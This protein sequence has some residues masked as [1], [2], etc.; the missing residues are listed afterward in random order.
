MSATTRTGRRRGAWVLLVAFGLLALAAGVGLGPRHYAEEGLTSVATTGLVLLVVGAALAAWGTFGVLAGTRR[1]WWALVLPLVL[2]ATYLSLWTLGQAV[3]A[4]YPPRPELGGRTPADVGLTYREV[5]FPSGDGV[6]LSGWYVPGSNGSAL[7]LMHGAGS[8]RSA[9]LDHASVLAAHGYAV[10]LFDARGHGESEGRGMDFGWYGE[11]D[12]EGAVDFLVEQPG[13]DPERIGL[14][15]TSMGGE[16]AIGAAGADDRV[17]AVVAEGATNRVAADKGYLE[18]AYGTRGQVQQRI[19]AL[20]YWFT[21]L[22]T[23]APRPSALRDSVAAAT[24]RP[25]HPAFLVIAAGERPDE[26]LVADYLQERGNGLVQTW[27]VPGAGH[28][29]AMKTA[30]DEWESRVLAFLDDSLEGEG[31]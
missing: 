3:A 11:A 27:T 18:D 6:R 29:Q 14:V 23:E 8:T 15:G 28:T 2:V 9:E 30:P 19:D 5:A 4:S 31:R 16:Q 13:V 7:V 22:L 21:D 12:A 24:G 10:L 17:A 26:A 1:R 20:T 25:D